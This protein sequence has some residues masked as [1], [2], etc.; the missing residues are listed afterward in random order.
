M[1]ARA[2]EKAREG[3]GKT[4]IERQDTRCAASK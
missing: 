1:A 2:A 3:S 4:T